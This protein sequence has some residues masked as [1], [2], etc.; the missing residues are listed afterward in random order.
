[1]LPRVVRTALCESLAVTPGM[2]QNYATS[3]YTVNGVLLES[4]TQDGGPYANLKSTKPGARDKAVKMDVPGASERISE[5]TKLVSGEHDMN[6]PATCRAPAMTQFTWKIS[7]RVRDFGTMRSYEATNEEKAVG[8]GAY[9]PLVKD[10]EDKQE[11][12]LEVDPVSESDRLLEM[13]RGRPVETV[14]GQDPIQVNGSSGFKLHP[15][16]PTVNM[17]SI[18]MTHRVKSMPDSSTKKFE[19]IT[20]PV[21][22]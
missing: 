17:L 8:L 20:S 5:N 15:I 16:G 19:V 2:V 13:L 9:Q 4:L 7:G 14:L 22:N 11:Y 3:S 18:N 1:M 21:A 6:L 12:T 10:I